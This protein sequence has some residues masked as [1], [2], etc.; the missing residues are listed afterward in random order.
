M[1]KTSIDWLP[2]PRLNDCRI[3][4]ATMGTRYSA[5]FAAPPQ[6]GLGGVAAALDAAVAAV[7][8]QMSNWRADSDLTRLNQAAPDRWVP[9]P[10]ELAT[11]LSRA[12]EI[13]RESGNAF[14]IGVGDLVAA[15]GFGPAPAHGPQRPAA[16]PRPPAHEMLELDLP[17]GRARKHGPVALDLCG[18]AK[19][20]GVDELAR[21]LDAQGLNSWL[22]GID[23]ELRTRGTRPD[24]AAWAIALEA[25]RD[26]LR[27]AMGVVELADAAVATSGDYRH[28]VRVDGRRVSHTMDPRRGAPLCGGLAA[29]TVIAGCCMDADAY[30][31]ALMV[32][33]EGEGL[34]LAGRLGLDALFVSRE[35]DGLRAA[36]TGA[37]GDGPPASRPAG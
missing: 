9:I 14:N 36:G 19:G 23:G 34:A 21:L 30:A 5:R 24:G 1:S 13:G 20:F 12:L 6:A 27:T 8:R 26:D 16:A 15:W 4:G 7:D 10:P 37:L 28:W 11:V 17:N 35:G 29:V 22:V 18:I 3:S 31:T 33:G 2:G 25:P 32:A